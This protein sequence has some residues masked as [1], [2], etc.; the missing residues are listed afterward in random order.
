MWWCIYL[1]RLC[2]ICLGR[3]WASNMSARLHRCAF[4]CL[5]ISLLCCMDSA[6]VCCSPAVCVCLIEARAELHTQTHTQ[7][8]EAIVHRMK[9]APQ[10]VYI[11]HIH[12]LQW[13]WHPPAGFC[14]GVSTFIYAL[15]RIRCE[16]IRNNHLS[17]SL[18]CS[19]NCHSL[20]SFSLSLFLSRSLSCSFSQEGGVNFECCV[21]KQ[22]MTNHT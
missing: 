15:E 5:S 19:C 6:A 8:R 18:L 17:E 16:T 20:S 7:S 21:Y 13:M 10:H 4:P 11:Y 9:H 12:S 22:Q 3:F 1:Q 2:P 14:E